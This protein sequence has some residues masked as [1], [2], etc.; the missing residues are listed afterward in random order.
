MGTLG[1]ENCSVSVL[2]GAVESRARF[3]KEMEVGE[4]WEAGFCWWVGVPRQGAQ[5]PPSQVSDASHCVWA[6]LQNGE[7]LGFGG[8]L[9]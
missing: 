2:V 5:T 1:L 3:S 9:E 7:G 6:G 4:V 8:G